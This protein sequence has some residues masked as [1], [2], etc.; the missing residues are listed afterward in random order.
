MPGTPW[1]TSTRIH[2]FLEEYEILATQMQYTDWQ[3]ARHVV[4][5][6][7]PELKD[8][9]YYM[10][11]YEDEDWAVLQAH[12]IKRFDSKDRPHFRQE[13]EQLVKE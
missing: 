13:L 10:I 12:L 1:F 6:V 9:I 11:P 3:K 8:Q 5:Y 4:D 7:S 2:Q